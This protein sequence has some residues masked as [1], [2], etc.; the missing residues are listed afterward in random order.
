MRSSRNSALASIGIMSPPFLGFFGRVVMSFHGA[1]LHLRVWCGVLRCFCYWQRGDG[2]CHSSGSQESDS[3]AHEVGAKGHF[4]FVFSV[5]F[6][7]LRESVFFEARENVC[8]V[9]VEFAHQK[10]GIQDELVDA[11]GILPGTDS[12][13]V[14]PLPGLRECL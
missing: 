6:G 9:E 1:S 11:L 10:F 7:S 2:S 5:V 13:I 4:E 3:E 12:A 14:S 8:Q